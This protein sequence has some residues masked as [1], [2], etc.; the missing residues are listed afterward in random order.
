MKKSSLLLAALG[1]V[2]G[3]FTVDAGGARRRRRQDRHDLAAHR[4]CRR[5][6]GMPP[7]PRSSSA[8]RSSI[9]PHPE[10]GRPAARR[11][12]RAAQSRRRQ[13]RAHLRRPS[14]QSL[15]SAQQLATR[16]I[17]PGQSQCADVGAYQS[18]CTLTATAVAER[19]GI[20]FMVGESSLPT[21][22]ARG[23]KWIVPRAR[24]SR[25]ISP[26]TYM[27]FFADMKKAGQE[28]RLDRHR[29]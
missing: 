3:A 20:P 12:R 28:G 9:S 23:F 5:R 25:P 16:L 8:P 18:S 22:P 10:L 1:A 26:R 7:R 6:R 11:G 29:Q 15:A 27:R 13:A 14:G 17:T 2:A 4:Q 24:R 21:S 19:Y